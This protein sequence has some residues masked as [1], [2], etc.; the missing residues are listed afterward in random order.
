MT[1]SLGTQLASLLLSVIITLV[2]GGVLYRNGRWFLLD[3][4]QGDEQKVDAVNR[5]LLVGFYLVNL[6]FVLLMLRTG[7]EVASFAESLEQVS[8]GVGM[9]ATTLGGMHF[10]NVRLLLIVRRRLRCPP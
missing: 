3:V 10:L 4:F 7:V 6:A 5:L 9:I 2:V 8:Q 1:I